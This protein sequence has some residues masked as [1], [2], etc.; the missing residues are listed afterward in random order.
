[1]I[2]KEEFEAGY[3]ER[4]RTTKEHYKKHFVTRP[5]SCDEECC[6]G[7]AAVGHDLVEDHKRLY[8]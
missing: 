1:M 5:C 7:W 6:P 3:I 8:E 4:T 2:T